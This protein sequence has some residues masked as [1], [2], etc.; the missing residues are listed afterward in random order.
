M[1]RR[2]AGDFQIMAPTIGCRME[3]LDTGSVVFTCLDMGVSEKLQPVWEHVYRDVDSILLVV[4]STDRRQL[5][6]VRYYLDHILARRSLDG[7]QLIV[8]ANKQDLP[9]ALSARKVAD[10]LDLHQLQGREW[11]VV[12]IC[13]M[14]GRGVEQLMKD[15]VPDEAP[16]RHH[17]AKFDT[18]MLTSNLTESKK[19]QYALKS[20]RFQQAFGIAKALP[21]GFAFTGLMP[22]FT[23]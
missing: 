21:K 17:G 5:E 4:D 11:N 3:S 20:P 15:F 1:G 8:A 14:S 10:R 22:S 12:E 2:I 23:A 6:Q 19:S 16:R 7:C 9:G 18:S 13:A